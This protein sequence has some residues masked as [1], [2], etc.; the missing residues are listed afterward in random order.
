[1]ATGQVELQR[2]HALAARCASN[3]VAAHVLDA[4]QLR[5]REPHIAGVGALWVPATAIADYG[6]VARTMASRIEAQGADIRLGQCVRAI[7]ERADE[8][9]V[10]TTTHSFRARRLVV[11]AGLMADRLA[12]CSNLAADFRIVP[13]RGEY[14]RLPPRMAGMIRHLIYPIPDPKLPFLG[15]H[16]TRTVAG[17]VIVGPNAVLSLS[18]EGYAKTAFDLGDALQMVRF[19]GFRRLARRHLRRAWA[20]QTSSWFRSSYA[21]LCRKYCPEIQASDLGPYPSGVRAQVVMRD[22]TL[23]HDFLLRRT[24]RTLHVCNAPSPAATAAIPIGRHIAAEVAVD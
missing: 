18:R 21:R 24:A 1:V 17:G 19:A 4:A 12:D 14:Y 9:E 20:E 7:Q 15:V 22:G 8:V 11:C 16:L 2:M 10:R 3:G 6:A 5:E 23:L 13:F